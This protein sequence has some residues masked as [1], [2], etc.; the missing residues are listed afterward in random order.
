M[1]FSKSNTSIWRLASRLC[2]PKLNFNDKC[3]I[4]LSTLASM[5]TMTSI[6][7][8]MLTQTRNIFV[9]SMSSIY[10]TSKNDNAAKLESTTS[11][12]VSLLSQ[13][14]QKI[15]PYYR[16]MRIDRP[17]GSWLLFWPCSWGIALSTAPGCIPNLCLLAQFGLAAFIMRGA[18]CTINDMWDRGI[19]QKVERTKGRPLASGQISQLDALMFLS[20]QLSGGL[21]M[22]L[23][24]NWPSIIFGTCS[25]S[26][27]IAY[28]LMK[29]ITHW[30]QLV[31]GVA[32]N[33]GTILGWC[34]TQG[35]IDWAVCLPLFASGVCWTIVYDTIYAHQVMLTLFYSTE[36]PRIKRIFSLLRIVS[37]M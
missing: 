29:R 10:S 30:P 6:N 19:D 8:H 1:N 25:M 37:M 28:P 35:S 22:L 18:G 4:R 32:F 17:V 24:L 20:A 11:A 3:S 31:L 36:R 5:Q 33:W 16:L 2:A 27:V 9:N 15:D 26:L 34:A 13:S 12:N 14:W 7:R 23:Q 21:I